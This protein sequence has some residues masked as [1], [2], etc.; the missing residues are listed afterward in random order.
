MDHGLVLNDGQ[1]LP[2]MGFGT[3]MLKGSICR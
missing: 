2:S 1:V 3:F